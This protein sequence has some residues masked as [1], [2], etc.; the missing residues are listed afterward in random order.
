MTKLIIARH[1]NTFDEGQTVLRVGKR[2]DLPLSQ[3]GKQ[4]AKALGYYLQTAGLLPQRV[5]TSTLQRTQQTAQIALEAMKL[6]RAIEPLPQFDEI[7]YGPDEGKPE[8]EVVAR[9]GR[10]ALYRWEKEAAVPPGWV[11]NPEEIKQQWKRFAFEIFSI[12]QTVLVVTSNGIA[13]FAPYILYNHADF[14]RDH[15]PKLKTGAVAEFHYTQG[16]WVCDSWGIV[17]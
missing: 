9:L 14:F 3:S 1:G 10:E 12:P 4:Q 13:R 17:P 5:A 16:R 7:D 15:D 8:S 11:A 2:T 6:Q